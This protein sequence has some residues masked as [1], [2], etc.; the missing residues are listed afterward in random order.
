MNFDLIK[1]SF[2]VE[3][4]PR[5]I[6]TTDIQNIYVHMNYFILAFN[7]LQGGPATGDFLAR[8]PDKILNFAHNN[9]VSY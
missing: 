1:K 7:Y 3:E 4:P 2:K 6:Y 8:Y 9:I 5:N